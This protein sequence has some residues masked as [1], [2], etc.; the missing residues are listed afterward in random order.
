MGEA[1]A[2]ALAVRIE[3]LVK[4]Y[5]RVTALDGV[6]LEIARRE[7]FGLLGANGAG[8][9]TLIRCLL[10]LTSADAGSI[11]IFGRSSREPASRVALAY[12]PERFTPPH[13]L[14]G[15]EFLR[16]LAQLAGVGYDAAR[17]A[18]LVDELELER[19]A[20]ERPVRNLSKG[21]TQK[22]G[23]AGCFSLEREMYVL[24][25]PMSGLDPAARVAV[26]SVLQRLSA[27]GRTLFFTSHVLADVDELCSSIA[28]LDHA[29]LRFRGAPQGLC[30]RYGEQSLERAF[31]RCIRDDQSAI[32]A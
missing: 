1:A 3:A 9:T 18:R 22:L 20:L 12:L 17:V 31:M 8:K 30:A 16:T 15:A 28:V 27:E 6:T 2:D 19:E 5:G 14:T 4:R 10:D 25:E 13:Y 21:M 7:A 32:T 26:K 29:R 23:L 24:D 11:Q